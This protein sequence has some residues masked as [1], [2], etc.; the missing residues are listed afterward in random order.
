MNTSGLASS[1]IAIVVV[2]LIIGV[3][4]GIYFMVTSSPRN[5]AS[6]G[7]NIGGEENVSI[8]TEV[9]ERAP[10]FT[11]TDI[12][13]NTFSLSDYRD[14]V[15]IVDFMATWCTWCVYEMPDL[16]NFHEDYSSEGVVMLSVDVTTSETRE[17]LRSFKNEYGAGW[18][19][20]RDTANV[21]TTYKVVG[22][23]TKYMINQNGVIVWKHSGATSYSTLESE[24]SK[25]L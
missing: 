23:P 4:G 14:N 3:M 5:S 21:G 22:I 9:G 2:G 12:D 20:A 13:G 11:L 6:G 16:V 8:G 18:T 15:V 24:V 17:Q 7:E 1:I 25:L 10:D 19:F